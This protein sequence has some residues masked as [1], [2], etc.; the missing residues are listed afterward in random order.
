MALQQL[1]TGTIIAIMIIVVAIACKLMWD[2]LC[3][4]LFGRR[5]RVGSE[6]DAYVSDYSKAM[7]GNDTLKTS[8][9]VTSKSSEESKVTAEE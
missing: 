7:S 2:R 9:N 6:L 5:H 8:G 3:Y 1:T 4:T